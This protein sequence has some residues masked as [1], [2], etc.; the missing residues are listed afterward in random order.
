MWCDSDF[1]RLEFKTM[2]VL[3]Y[4]LSS[5]LAL[6][7]TAG[8]FVDQIAKN[9][10][11]SRFNRVEQLQVRVDNVPSYQIVQ[12]KVER[13][14]IAGRGLWLTPDARIAA[15]ELETDPVNVNIQRLRQPGQQLPTAALRQPVQAGLRLVLTEADINKA[16]QSPAVNAQLQ[17]LASRFLGNLVNQ[18][19]QG[20]KLLNPRIEFLADN[21]LRLQVELESTEP[22]QTTPRRLP[23]VLE[24]G[25]G[26]VSGRRLQFIEP[27]ASID[28][29]S[30]PSFLLAPLAQNFSEQFDL[31]Q[32]EQQAGITARLLQ[33][34]I[35]PD[36]MEIA[37]FV[38]VQPSASPQ[39]NQN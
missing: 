25:V 11:G 35:N 1:C 15:V 5:V 33:L 17:N 31:A 26:I 34:K 24:S 20:V 29:N 18:S 10:I 6:L 27:T 14:R 8:I 13:V 19:S 39:K 4:L 28:N 2:E 21:R 16:L 7:S 38:R 9:A 22:N 30:I 37:A 32:L 23:I 3:T 36:Q 12:G